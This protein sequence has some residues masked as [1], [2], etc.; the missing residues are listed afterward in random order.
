M[1]IFALGQH[2]QGI[3]VPTVL[4]SSMISDTLF[5]LSFNSDKDHFRMYQ[6]KRYFEEAFKFNKSKTTR[7]NEHLA[8]RIRKNSEQ[9]IQQ[10]HGAEK[11]PLLKRLQTCLPIMED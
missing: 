7:L 4:L 8:K 2:C 3:P 11:R 10:P 1:V 9:E 5:E 6:W